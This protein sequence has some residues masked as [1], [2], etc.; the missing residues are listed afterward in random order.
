M[1]SAFS[2]FGLWNEISLF[3]TTGHKNCDDMDLWRIL[4][5]VFAKWSPTVLQANA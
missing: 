4:C 5:N 1:K 2:N 3:Q